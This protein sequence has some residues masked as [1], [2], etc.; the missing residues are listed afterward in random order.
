VGDYGHGLL[1]LV[2]GTGKA[3]V[4]LQR[5]RF[6]I[7][8][9]ALQV[10][11][12]D[13]TKPFWIARASVR[14]NTGPGKVHGVS[15]VSR[16][17]DVALLDP[18]TL[19]TD[20]RPAKVGELRWFSKPARRA[21]LLRPFPTAEPWSKASLP[22]TLV[23]RGQAR[24]GGA[25]RSTVPGP[26][27][28]QRA[29]T[30]ANRPS[31]AAKAGRGSSS[32]KKMT[33]GS[34][35]PVALLARKGVDATQLKFVPSLGPVDSGLG[36]YYRGKSIGYYSR[37]A[38]HRSMHLDEKFHGKGIGTIAYLVMAKLFHDSRRGLLSSDRS[39][40]T[41][42]GGNL[43][44]QAQSVWRRFVNSGYAEAHKAGAHTVYQMKQ[45]AIDSVSWNRFT[46]FLVP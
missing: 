31:T 30:A 22:A 24:S 34:F 8:S 16:G 5:T 23:T 20:A 44:P 3:R 35:D 25:A 29:S 36:I 42:R 33:P 37:D 4:V 19:K 41:D 39:S 11:L 26:A 15:G 32:A 18:L 45:S 17:G 7:G 38:T 21:T 1:R 14:E 6:E 43:S 28:E 9:E 27:G 2:A 13:R 12:G 10:Q 40:E 46:S